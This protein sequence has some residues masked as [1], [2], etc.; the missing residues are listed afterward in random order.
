M[1]RQRVIIFLAVLILIPAVTYGL[2]RFASGYRPDLQ[3]GGLKATGLLS[4]TSHPEGAQVFVDGELRT[5]TDDTLNLE[6]GTYEVE[7]KK[8]GFIAWK[9]VLEIEKE[10]VTETQTRLFPALPELR[11]LTTNGAMRPR[12]SANGSRIAYLVP[13]ATE[14]AEVKGRNGEVEKAKSGVWLLELGNLPLGF[15]QEPRQLVVGWPSGRENQESQLLWSYDSRQM[16]WVFPESKEEVVKTEEE[17]EEKLEEEGL[18]VRVYLINPHETVE[19]AELEDVTGRLNELLEVWDE[20]RVEQLERQ[21]KKLP[22]GAQVIF[23]E[24]ARDW[25]FSL[26]EDKLMYVATQA[27][28][29][30]KELIPPVVASSTQTEERELTVVGIYVYDFKED[31]NFRVGGAPTEVR[32]W[33]P[34]YVKVEDWWQVDDGQVTLAWFPT[35]RHLV[36][37]EEGKVS[38]VEY[39]RTNVAVVYSGS[40]EENFA[41][42]HPSGNS[43]ILLT[44][45]NP[46]ASEVPNLYSLNLR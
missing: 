40:L 4:A 39:D 7:I 8:D 21:M 44:V 22:E 29:L 26:E 35:S 28:E 17:L 15:N 23:E 13:E 9:K 45:L 43:L 11:P 30:E 41:V 1:T 31:R 3:Q 46:G 6:P 38:L 36:R 25:S 20:E 24:R 12:L 2:I 33:A 18:K 32:L 5:A 42:P 34:E 14:S 27:G 37:V 16:V 19:A 10:L